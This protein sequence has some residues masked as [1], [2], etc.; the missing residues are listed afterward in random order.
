[1]RMYTSYRG[2]RSTGGGAAPFGS[3]LSACVFAATPSLAML[4]QLLVGVVVPIMPVLPLMYE[5]GVEARWKQAV[6]A[7]LTLRGAH[8]ERVG[9]FVLGVAGVPAHPAPRDGATGIPAS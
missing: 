2:M 5:P 4:M 7:L 9:V 1:M 6:G 8:R 3:R